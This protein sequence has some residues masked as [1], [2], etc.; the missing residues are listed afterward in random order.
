MHYLMYRGENR[1]SEE[2][3]GPWSPAIENLII[4]GGHS[5]FIG[6]DFDKADE[7]DSWYLENYQKGQLST[8]LQHLRRGVELAAKDNSSLLLFSGGQ[9]RSVAGPRSESLSYWSVADAKN[10]FGIA[11]VRWRALTEEYARDSFENLIFSVCRFREVVGRYPKN[12]TVISFSFKK[13]RFIE[14]HRAAIRFP[15]ERFF[16]EGLDPVGAQN[17]LKAVTSEHDNAVVPFEKDPYGC[18]PPLSDK[19]D[20]RNPFNRVQSYP[21]GCP[22]LGALMSYCGSGTFQGPLPWHGNW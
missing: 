21:R 1:A 10:W 17:R 18:R 16:F 19:R 15:R 20:S 4:V 3:Q 5:V 7:E 12:I 11:H 22:E 9:T 8:M 14:Q 2:A 13:M 6:S